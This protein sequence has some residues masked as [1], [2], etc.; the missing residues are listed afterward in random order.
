MIILTSFLLLL[1][2]YLII[3]EILGFYLIPIILVVIVA[4]IPYLVIRIFRTISYKKFISNFFIAACFLQIVIMS[5]ILW[6]ATPRYY[7]HEQI[8]KDIDYAI[9]VMEDVHPNLYAV[10]SK[11]VFYAKGSALIPIETIASISDNDVIEE[12]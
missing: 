2:K 6:S 7:S 1:S 10:I 12:S 8:N 3:E 5:L 11:E 9:K 4:T